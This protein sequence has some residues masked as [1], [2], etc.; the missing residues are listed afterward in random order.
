[1]GAPGSQRRHPAARHG[2]PAA[3]PIVTGGA[4][5]VV[6]AALGRRRGYRYAA[7]ATAGGIPRLAERAALALGREHSGPALRHGLPALAI[8]TDHA[9]I[10]ARACEVLFGE[11][12]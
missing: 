5:G 9:V 11:P 12:S 1:M 6:Q 7:S 2:Q 3:R 4:V 10:I 8:R